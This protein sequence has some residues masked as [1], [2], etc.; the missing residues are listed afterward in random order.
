[1]ALSHNNISS[2]L[3]K[4][5]QSGRWYSAENALVPADALAVPNKPPLILLIQWYK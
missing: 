5:Q 3:W 2:V 1:M 4:K